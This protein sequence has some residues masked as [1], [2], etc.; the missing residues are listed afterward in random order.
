M[1]YADRR[2]AGEVA[3]WSDSLQIL[4]FDGELPLDLSFNAVEDRFPQEVM[5][6]VVVSDRLPLSLLMA[7][8]PGY[9]EV[10]GRFPD[11]WT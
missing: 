2:A 6:L 9:E 5:D 10:K 3:L 8:F 4:T 7:P 1:D 11:A